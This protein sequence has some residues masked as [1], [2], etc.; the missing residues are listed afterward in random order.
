MQQNIIGANKRCQSIST[1]YRAY[2]SVHMPIRLYAD[3]EANFESEVF[4]KVCYIFGIKKIRTTHL[5]PYSNWV[6]IPMMTK[7]VRNCGS[8]TYDKQKDD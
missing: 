8:I 3:Q 7:S 6:I 5:N 1:S 2:H 4:Q